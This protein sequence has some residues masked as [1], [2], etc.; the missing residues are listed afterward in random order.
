MAPKTGP[1]EGQYLGITDPQYVY[2]YIK[3]FGCRQ[4]D[5]KVLCGD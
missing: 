5:L 3:Y 2:P 4:D 1:D